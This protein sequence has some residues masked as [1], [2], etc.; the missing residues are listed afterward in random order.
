VLPG[1]LKKCN[2]IFYLNRHYQQKNYDSSTFLHGVDVE[3]YEETNL[4][5]Y[6]DIFYKLDI[7]L[8]I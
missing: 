2:K 3:C 6:A 8:N 4:G 5:S 1:K 7:N